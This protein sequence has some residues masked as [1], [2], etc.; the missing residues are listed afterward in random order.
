MIALALAAVLAAEKTPAAARAVVA[1]YYAAIEARRYRD[2]YRCWDRGGAA[3]GQSLAAFTRGFARTRRV[4]VRTGAPT[5][6]EG[7]AGSAFVTVP[8]T[9]SATLR[10]GT[11]QRFVGSY[12]LRRVNDVDGATPAQLRWHLASARLRRG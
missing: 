9:V 2:A 7:A 4:T 6:G 11:P 3:S 10:D 8:V 5:D 12:V 1:R